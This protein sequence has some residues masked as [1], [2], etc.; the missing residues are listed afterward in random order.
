VKAWP[1][2]ILVT[3]FGSFPGTREN[4]TARLIRALGAHRARLARLGI[5]L[6]LKLLPVHFAEVMEKLEALDVTL[7]T[8][9]ILHFGLAA[10]QRYFSVETRALNRVSL[11]HC[12][13]S[14]ARASCRAIVPGAEHIARSTFPARQIE[15]A[16]RRAGF[17]VHLSSNTGDYVCNATLIC[18]SRARMPERSALFMCRGWPASTGRGG[19]RDTPRKSRRPDPR[20][21]NRDPRHRPK[22][23]PVRH[24]PRFCEW[25]TQKSGA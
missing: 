14:G 20:R 11:L 1:L 9:A 18:R 4:P 22:P 5:V 3:G 16:L 24:A 12:D 2:R 17:H 21:P 19:Y 6:E 8:D 25:A 13:V 23:P 10:R 15:A 7:K